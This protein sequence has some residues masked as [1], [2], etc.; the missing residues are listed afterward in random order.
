MD[1]ER[2]SI[3]RQS[4]GRGKT[5]ASGAAN[6]QRAQAGEGL[7]ICSRHRVRHRGLDYSALV[8]E[9]TLEATTMRD[10]ATTDVLT[11]VLCRVEGA[12][13]VGAACRAIKTM[14]FCRLAL[15]G[16]PPHD[17]IEV[18]TH[19]LHAFDVYEAATRYETLSAAL[20]PHAL[21]AGFTR[22]TGQRR[23]HNVPVDVFA[24]TIAERDGG[25][26][27]LVFGNERDG[28]SDAEL[29]LCD[30]AVSIATSPLFPSLN[31]SHAVQIACWEVRKALAAAHG[32]EAGAASGP[33]GAHRFGCREHRRGHCKRQA[34]SRWQDGRKRKS[35]CGVS[36]PGQDC[37]SPSWNDSPTFSIPCLASP[38]LI[39]TA[40]TRDGTLSIS[41]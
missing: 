26:V 4:P 29:D 32:H 34:C 37:P 20:E 33:T 1:D 24:R 18:R 12:M 41:K 28:L 3:G 8:M 5:Y 30:H 17:E 7:L 9:R 2:G 13:N 25:S 23:K 36:L 31:L 6:D 22:R 16:C 14:G 11:V 35:S 27:A 19:A 10:E 38:R 15:A 21:V 39:L 40:P